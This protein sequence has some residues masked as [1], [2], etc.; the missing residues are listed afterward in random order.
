MTRLDMNFKRVDGGN[1][2]ISIDDAKV[3]VTELEVNTLMDL[4][5]TNAIFQPNG[6]PLAEKV[7]IELVTTEVVEFNIV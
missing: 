2:K 6:S 5:L 7:S 1:N 4:I 3:D